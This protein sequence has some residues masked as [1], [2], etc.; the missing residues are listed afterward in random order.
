MNLVLEAFRDVV[1]IN[2]NRIALEMSL[3][4]RDGPAG[5]MTKA[6]AGNADTGYFYLYRS[7]KH[8]DNVMETVVSREHKDGITSVYKG[9]HRIFGSN[10]ELMRARLRLITEIA[11]EVGLSPQAVGIDDPG[12]GRQMSLQE[13]GTGQLI[14]LLS[15]RSRMGIVTMKTD[16]YANGEVFA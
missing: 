16:N 1:V 14:D 9:N 2:G 11:A 5:D 3:D 6:F 10:G 12:R 15:D 7:P 4:L 8:P 13:L